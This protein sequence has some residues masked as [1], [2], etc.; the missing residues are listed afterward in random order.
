MKLLDLTKKI[1]SNINKRKSHMLHHMTSKI[2][3]RIKKEKNA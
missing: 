1:M 2:F 3:V